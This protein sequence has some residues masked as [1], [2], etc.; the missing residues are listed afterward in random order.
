[1]HS[2]RCR[3]F[4]SQQRKCFCAE[5]SGQNEQ[6]SSAR[7]GLVST[8]VSHHCAR[9]APRAAPAG[10]APKLQMNLPPPPSR[11]VPPAPPPKPTA[12]TFCA[13]PLPAAAAD[14]FGL[15][16]LS[17]PPLPPAAP[18]AAPA[19]AV[20]A[21]FTQPNL[22]DDLFHTP[23]AGLHAAPG[24][25][26]PAFGGY[27]AFPAV[28]GVNGAAAV[29]PFDL[30][31]GPATAPAAG[32]GGFGLLLPPKPAPSAA[33]DPFLSFPPP[34]VVPAANVGAPGV[35]VGVP[36]GR[37]SGGMP[38]GASSQTRKPATLEEAMNAS[39]NLLS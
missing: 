19:Y 3:R 31:S 36:M 28:G 22:L 13:P 16:A 14:A 33:M 34:P 35:S 9:S 25:G 2:P 11:L 20:N 6:V 24:P 32:A 37:S 23:A 8:L 4:A 10:P 27:P 38:M 12:T 7:C 30:L 18:L 17:A 1:M 21:A 5:V 26:Q 29:D 15:S 39:L